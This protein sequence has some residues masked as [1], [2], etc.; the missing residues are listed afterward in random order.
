MP[1]GLPFA[2][3]LAWA[4]AKP[5]QFIGGIS[6]PQRQLTTSCRRAVALLRNRISCTDLKSEAGQVEETALGPGRKSRPFLFAHDSSAT[7]SNSNRLLGFC[8]VVF[9][10]GPGGFTRGRLTRRSVLITSCGSCLLGWSGWLRSRRCR[11]RRR[12]RFLLFFFFPACSKH[13]AENH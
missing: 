7:P 9:F 11:W 1:L 2:D 5:L 8:R 13:K 3:I 12:W 6:T 10:L 4:S